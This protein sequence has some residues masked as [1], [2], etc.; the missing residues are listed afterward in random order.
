MSNAAM[1]KP[2]RHTLC[3]IAES[4]KKEPSSLQ[5]AEKLY[6]FIVKVVKYIRTCTGVLLSCSGINTQMEEVFSLSRFP[7]W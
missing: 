3:I 2:I 4:V 1:W 5:Q 7:I 6:R